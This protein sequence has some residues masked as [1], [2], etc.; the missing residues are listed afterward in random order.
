MHRKYTILQWRLTSQTTC[1]YTGNYA[2]I[3]EGHLC[4]LG[5]FEKQ[6]FD[7]YDE[8]IV[9]VCEPKTLDIV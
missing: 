8:N 3:N 6:Q 7:L 2:Y 4:G 5:K 1:P 9:M